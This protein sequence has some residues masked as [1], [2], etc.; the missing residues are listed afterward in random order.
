MQRP[1][2][3]KAIQ[4]SKSEH[5]ENSSL[6]LQLLVESILTAVSSTFQNMF[7]EINSLFAKVTDADTNSDA[8]YR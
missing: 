5:P 7:K 2:T 4:L 3:V 8:L 6:K 1:Q